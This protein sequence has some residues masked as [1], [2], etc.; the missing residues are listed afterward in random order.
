MTGMFEDR[1]AMLDKQRL[2]DVG[3][4]EDKFERLMQVVSLGI[5]HVA[6]GAK[7]AAVGDHSWE[8]ELVLTPGRSG[9][10]QNPALVAEQECRTP[11]SRKSLEAS[12]GPSAEAVTGAAGELEAAAAQSTHG[13][14]SPGAARLRP[15]GRRG[16]RGAGTP[17]RRGTAAEWCALLLRQLK[18]AEAGSRGS[19]R[20]GLGMI[21]VALEG[22]LLWWEGVV[23]DSVPTSVS[24]PIFGTQSCDN[25]PL[26]LCEADCEPSQ[27]MN[28]AHAGGRIEGAEGCGSETTT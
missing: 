13:V 20:V 18:A 2:E 21:R 9:V 16:G 5:A 12:L 27:K 3:R 25:N 11:P 4:Q 8:P 26:L 7:A 14:E 15:R 22:L 17:S 28:G 10:Q 1:F 24:P 23:G 19:V 6:E